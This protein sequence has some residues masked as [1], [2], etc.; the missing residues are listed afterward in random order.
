MISDIELAELISV[1]ICHD[2]SGPIGAISNGVEFFDDETSSMR[3]KAFQL[4]DISSRQAYYRLQFYRKIYGYSPEVGEA[5]LADIKTTIENYLSG[6]KV[7]LEWEISSVNFSNIFLSQ[8]H[9]KLI[10]NLALVAFGCLIYGGKIVINITKTNDLKKFIVTAIGT[11]YKVEPDNLK[12]LNDFLSNI[13]ITIRNVQVYYTRRLIS[14]LKMQFS[15][16]KTTDQISFIV[17]YPQ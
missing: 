6:K 13:T 9:A 4:V 15:T 17:E 12:I 10:M 1:K 7:Y 11:N 14:N 5:N 3:E 2:L 16:E 8:S